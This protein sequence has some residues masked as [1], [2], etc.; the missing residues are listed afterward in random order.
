MKYVGIVIDDWCYE[1]EDRHDLWQLYCEAKP[2]VFAE[3]I[4]SEASKQESRLLN[5]LKIRETKSE[6]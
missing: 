2:R 4:F 6:K 1:V 3:A 5:S